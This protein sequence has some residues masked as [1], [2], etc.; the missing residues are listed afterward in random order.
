MDEATLHI[1]ILSLLP[2]VV[3]VG[4]AV[5]TKRVIESLLLGIMSGT[6]MLDA[7][8]NGWGH[9]IPFA[10]VNLV[11]AIAGHPENEELGLKGMGLLQSP[12]RAYVIM[13]V[14]LLGSFITI[15]NK[16]GGAMAFGKWLSE[17]VKTK[18]GA[19]NAT[20]IMGCCLF[21]SAYFS[22]LATG[23]VFRPIFDRMKMSRAKLGFL[24]DSTSAPINCLIP[25]SGWVAYMSLLMMDNIPGCTDGLQGLIHTVPYNFYCIFL[26]I[27]VFLLVNGKIKDFGPMVK[28]DREALEGHDSTRALEGALGEKKSA[29]SNKNG[30]VSD[31]M[32]PLGV[33][34]GCLVTLGLWN[35]TIIKFTSLPRIPLTGNQI[36]I[37]SF[38]LGILT[39]FA[40]YTLS[41]LMSA[42]EF[43]D[44]ALEGTK[45]AIIGG[46]IIVLAVTLGDL[47]RDSAPEGVGAA[48]YLQEVAGKSIPPSIVPFGIF[49]LASLMG[50]A[51]GTSWGVWA[52]C[53]PIAIPLTVA[54]GGNPYIAAAAVLSGGTFGDHCSPISDT[55]IMSS[56]GSGCNHIDHVRTQI[57]YG[58]T[59][60]GIASIAYLIAGFIF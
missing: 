9:S 24:I 59:A 47:V 40:K 56:I 42:S 35:Y 25:I 45:S 39:G 3:A 18:R 52:I 5:W 41:G 19:Q 38:V 58:A 21:T 36:L 51:T 4:L 29:K 60:A 10:L 14:L 32:L 46:M 15:L 17:R 55:C 22:S 34:V 6:L 44:D 31:M 7:Q 1:G 37:T 11:K 43:L 57:P 27:F 20:A 2:P 48:I 12:E 30:T 23:T 53:M 16:S 13:V 33:S 54:G 26:L 8:I 49:L 28:A 50:L